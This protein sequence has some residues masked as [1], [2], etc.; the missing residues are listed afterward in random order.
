[1]KTSFIFI[2]LVVATL[3]AVQWLIST[4][5]ASA[6]SGETQLQQQI[7][8]KEREELDSLKS[9]DMTLFSSLLADNAVFVDAHG[10][11]AKD[12]VVQHTVGFRLTEF[13]MEDV[14]FVPVSSNSGL[15]A[16]RL[17]ET[18]TYQGKEFAGEVYVS[19]LWTEKQGKWVC[20]FSQET[21]AK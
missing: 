14:K 15:I 9:G 7:V 4:R 11:A 6:Q 20:L 8:A 17:T 3:L 2:G 1:M 21:A 18:G 13:T 16:Y 5:G 10:S 19:A 12:E